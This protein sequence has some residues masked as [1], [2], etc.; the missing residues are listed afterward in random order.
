MRFEQNLLLSA[1]A[2]EATAR[3]LEIRHQ[4]KA[5]RYPFRFNIEQQLTAQAAEEH[6]WVYVLKSRQ[7]GL[8]TFWL[9][10]DVMWVMAHDGVGAPVR[11]V[12]LWDDEDNIKEKIVICKDLAEQ[13]GAVV[14]PTAFKLRFA[15]GS[16]IE[17]ITAGGNNPG[18]G[19]SGADRIHASEMPYWKGAKETW[20]GVTALLSEHQSCTLETTMDVKE[21]TAQELWEDDENPFHKLF[22]PFSLHEI[23]R[24]P[25]RAELLR[26]DQLELLD[27]EG[28]PVFD[29]DPNEAADMRAAGA[30]WLRKLRADMRNDWSLLFKD[31]PQIPAHA[32]AV[33]DGLWC[34][35]VPGT[36][37]PL[38]IEWV[39]GAQ[40]QRYPLEIWRH[41]E[42]VRG[43][44]TI[45]VD[46]AKGVGRDSSAVCARDSYDGALCAT[47]ADNLILYNGLARVA[48]RCQDV[49]HIKHGGYAE[50]PREWRKPVMGVEVNGCG[51]NTSIELTAAGVEHE[52]LS[53]GTNSKY[54]GM[55]AAKDAVESGAAVGPERLKEE[56]R[57]CY[58]EG[59]EFKGEKDLLM[60]YGFATLL[61]EKRLGIKPDEEIR[62]KNPYS[63]RRRALRRAL[64]AGGG[65]RPF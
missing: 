11:C 62:P 31:F 16:T 23:Y 35:K 24:D 65:L 9:L 61:A 3:N 5:G 60:S 10:W 58:Y 54:R 59:R 47:F 2:L 63:R 64:A 57:S 37:E 18:R 50:R 12:L 15:N 39:E 45:G 4:G 43:L 13:L 40:G 56:A 41:P 53:T 34:K 30:W 55:R 28:F 20:A 42:D 7:V 26:D 52:R 29:E 17:G 1:E 49:F 48:A 46:T 8:T 19:L 25:A 21:P 51:D 14:E 32:F 36:L 33:S 44:L 27:R 6:N 22:L 38:S